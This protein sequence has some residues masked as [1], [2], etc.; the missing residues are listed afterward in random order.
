MRGGGE[1]VWG[2]VTLLGKLILKWLVFCLSPQIIHRISDEVF[3][4]DTI[5]VRVRIVVGIP[6]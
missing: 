1:N 6:T 5:L 2:L 4:I 3:T